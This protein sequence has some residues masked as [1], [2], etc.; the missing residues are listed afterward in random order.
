MAEVD[1]QQL[2]DAELFQELDDATLIEL[3][4]HCK[5]RELSA[6]ETLFRQDDSGDALYILAAGQIH[7]VRVYPTGEEVI[8]ATEGP[9]YAIGEL[10]LLAQQPRTG[11]VV[12]V[13]DCTLLALERKAF[14]DTCAQMPEVAVRAL[15]YVSRRLYRMNLM[16]REHALGN[17]RARI[18]SAILLFADDGGV[19]VTRLARATGTDAEDIERILKQWEQDDWIAFD[20]RRLTIRDAANLQIIAG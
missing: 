16:V 7:V 4:A 1:Y 12:A 19:S 3:A 10:S 5:Y 8:L 15:D 9:Y 14:M 2:R 17:I 6:G 18:A 20:G 13:S 11:S